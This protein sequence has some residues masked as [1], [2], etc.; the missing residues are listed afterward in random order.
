MKF[1]RS[2]VNWSEGLGICCWDAP[3]RTTLASLFDE[4]GTPWDTMVEVEEHVV[5]ESLN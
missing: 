2:F 5:A 4:V 3:D 1:E